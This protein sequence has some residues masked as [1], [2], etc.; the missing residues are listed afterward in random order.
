MKLNLF[1]VDAFTDKPFAG[2][3]AAVCLLDAARDDEW[4]LHVAQEMNLSE[5]AFLLPQDDG[6]SLRWF[7]PATEVD[8]CGH[9]TLAS[10]HVLW[11]TGLLAADETARFY[12]RSGLLTAVFHPPYTE[13]NFPALSQ[14]PAEAP[15]E[16]LA[17]LGITPVYVGQCGTKY[18]IE[19]ANESIVRQLQP[20]FVALRQMPGRGVAI[21][22]ASSSP[23]YDFVSR[24]FAPWVGIDED[25]VTGSIHCC[26]GPFWGTR[27]GKERLTA[28]QASLRGGGLLIRLAGDRVYLGGQAVTVF[29][30]ELAVR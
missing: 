16:I 24:Y 25:P 28:F 19:V 30:G 12:T 26:L 21:T 23:D 7:T 3:P 15:P 13:L 14:T 9:A 29:R 5:T 17:A 2:N 20:D 27:L 6:Y 22:S 11:E 18:L 1:Q 10:A 4:M 8:L